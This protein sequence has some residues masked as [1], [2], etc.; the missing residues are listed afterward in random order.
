MRFLGRT[1]GA[2]LEGSPLPATVGGKRPQVMRTIHAHI[3]ALKSVLASFE[4]TPISEK[5]KG[6]RKNRKKD[7]RKSCCSSRDPLPNRCRPQARSLARLRNT[8]WPGRI[9][10]QSPHRD[11]SRW[12]G[13]QSSPKRSYLM[14][15]LLMLSDDMRWGGGAA[16]RCAQRKIDTMH[17]HGE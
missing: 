14:A 1:K 4:S 11:E 8:Y 17:A 6:K 9:R 12:S 3:T 10:Q 5:K 2:E 16:P 15:C 7:K 13:E